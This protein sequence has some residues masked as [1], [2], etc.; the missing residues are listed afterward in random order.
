M[1][2]PNTQIS[3]KA[4]AYGAL[5]GF[6]GPCFVSCIVGFIVM[7]S[8]VQNLPGGVEALSEPEGAAALAQAFEGPFLMIIIASCA[9][10]SLLGGY[11]AGRVG[12]PHAEANAKAVGYI[13]GGIS[14]LFALFGI[15][16]SF[17]QGFSKQ[18]ALNGS[19]NIAAS[20]LYYFMA[21]MGGRLAGPSISFEE[22]E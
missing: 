11:T 12:R 3:G 16:G 15:A 20:A 2:Q 8:A 18:G 14:L 7:F 10:G 6:F 1:H 5:I 19:I 22:A 9:L 13:L 4:V 17:A 21:V